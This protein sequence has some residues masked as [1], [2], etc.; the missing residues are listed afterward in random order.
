ME[1][2][3]SSRWRLASWWLAY[4]DA[5]VTDFVSVLGACSYMTWMYPI[6]HHPSHAEALD[7]GKTPKSLASVAA[8]AASSKAP[9]RD[10]KPEALKA[11]H[12]LN[13]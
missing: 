5:A 3:A 11:L 8:S 10:P 12:P 7:E 2:E 4:D 1:Q 13:P 9:D 6:T